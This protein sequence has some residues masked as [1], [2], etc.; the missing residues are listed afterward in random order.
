MKTT[1]RNTLLTGVLGLLA[2]ITPF[3]LFAGSKEEAVGD[4]LANN[5]RGLFEHKDYFKV[6]EETYDGFRGGR[7]ETVVTTKDNVRHRCVLLDPEEG[8]WMVLSRSSSG[9]RMDLG[10]MNF[11]KDNPR[12]SDEDL[13]KGRLTG[14]HIPQLGWIVGVHD[15]E[16]GVR[17]YSGSVTIATWKHV[18]FKDK[19]TIDFLKRV[20]V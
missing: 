12:Q 9:T 2:G 5:K 6:L 3:R 4:S 8:H 17:L 20:M 10:E 1:R 19:V 16:V 15:L 7:H 18:D 14:Y 13:L 11:F